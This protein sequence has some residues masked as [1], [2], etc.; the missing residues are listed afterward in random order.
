MHIS[1]GL[2]CMVLPGLL[3]D[4]SAL[5]PQ[6]RLLQAEV[7]VLPC[8]THSRVHAPACRACGQVVDGHVGV[9]L[10]IDIVQL[11]RGPAVGS[12]HPPQPAAG[13]PGVR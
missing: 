10:M 12:G 6:A 8:C 11:G 13:R 1:Q 4:G 7:T 3:A 5:V 9:V 2:K